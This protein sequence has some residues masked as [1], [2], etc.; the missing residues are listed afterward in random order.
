MVGPITYGPLGRTVH[1]PTPKTG[2]YVPVAKMSLAHDVWLA[3]RVTAG[4]VKFQPR[5]FK[6][7]TRFV[8]TAGDLLRAHPLPLLSDDAYFPNDFDVDGLGPSTIGTNTKATLAH[9]FIVTYLLPIIPG[10]ETDYPFPERLWDGAKLALASHNLDTLG[11]F[12]HDLGD[13]LALVL[14]RLGSLDEDPETKEEKEAVTALKFVPMQFFG[15]DMETRWQAHLGEFSLSSAAFLYSQGPIPPITSPLRWRFLLSR[16]IRFQKT[17]KRAM[18]S[19]KADYQWEE[20]LISGKTPHFG[21]GTRSIQAFFRARRGDFYLGRGDLERSVQM[22]QGAAELIGGPTKKSQFFYHLASE[23]AWRL[24]RAGVTDT[25]S[26]NIMNY[27]SL[28]ML[29]E[30]GGNRFGAWSMQVTTQATLFR[31]AKDLFNRGETKAAAVLL[32]IMGPERVTDWEDLQFQTD[33][34]LLE[35]PGLRSEIRSLTEGEKP[36][37]LVSLLDR[38]DFVAELLPRVRRMLEGGKEQET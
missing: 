12:F 2:C 28:V 18:K 11:T 21:W 1:S 4:L 34:M 16:L 17:L 35:N 15:W 36:E 8:Q 5:S 26:E 10:D 9:A 13:Y 7:S 29:F 6:P 31:L 25:Y 23:V 37:R 22:Y 24:Y 19:G 3:T 14:N 30:R 20:P 33:Q 27:R 32:Y 38:L